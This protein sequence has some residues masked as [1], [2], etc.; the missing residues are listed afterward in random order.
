MHIYTHGIVYIT[1][2][3]YNYTHSIRLKSL[4]LCTTKCL[5]HIEKN[6]VKAQIHTANDQRKK[7]FYVHAYWL[8]QIQTEEYKAGNHSSDL[9]GVHLLEKY[10]HLVSYAAVQSRQVR[11]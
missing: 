8:Q 9:Q 11:V 4:D 1:L 5:S 3:I 7:V 2:A 6:E 10:D